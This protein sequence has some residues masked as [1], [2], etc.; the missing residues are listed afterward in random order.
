MPVALSRLA[1]VFAS[2]LALVS[3]LLAACQTTSDQP[4]KP[5][6]ALY[7]DC[8]DDSECESGWCVNEFGNGFCALEC[9]EGCPAGGKCADGRDGP[10]CVANCNVGREGVYACVDATPVYCDTL[11][12]DTSCLACGCPEGQVCEV[13]VGC[14]ALGEPGRACNEDEDCVSEHC[15]TFEGERLCMPTIGSPCAC[16]DDAFPCET[17]ECGRCYGGVDV[18]DGTSWSMCTRGCADMVNVCPTNYGCVSVAGSDFECLPK[19]TSLAGCPSGE[20]GAV[21][22][23][24]FAEPYFVCKP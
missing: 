21:D 8:L 11:E 15:G 5:K 1:L 22:P 17:A 20:C 12:D 3:V 13:G 23:G 4:D 14:F 18:H 19:C 24:P 2:R 16:P 6:A 10:V 9:D 7:Q